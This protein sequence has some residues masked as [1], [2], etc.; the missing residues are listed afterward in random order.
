MDI[1]KFIQRNVSLASLTTFKIGGSAEYFV[2]ALNLEILKQSLIW[3]KEKKLPFFILGGGSNILV[4]DKGFSG[5]VIKNELKKLEKR[6]DIIIAGSGVFL[7]EFLEFALVN[8]LSGG[9]F[10]VGIPGT[11]GGAVFANAGLSNQFISNLVQ[12]VYFLDYHSLKIR[13]YLNKDC[14]FSYRYSCFQEKQGVITQIELKMKNSS[15]DKIKALMAEYRQKRANLPSL[16]SAGCVFKNINLKEIPP[17]S[18]EKIKKE[19]GF[20]EE[21]CKKGVLPVSWL[22]DRM[23]FKGKTIGKAQVSQKHAN[24]IVNLGGATADDVLILISLIKQKVRTKFGL[25]LCEEIVYLA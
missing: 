5:L 16:P 11:L 1:P 10:L 17:S 6:G 25:Q 20:P 7:S 23:G 15:Q 8:E 14:D 12:S 2:R 3:A 18:L 24:F 22:L 13:C 19:F 4:S 9:E 21:F